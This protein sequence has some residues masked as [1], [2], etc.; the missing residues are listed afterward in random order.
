MG[1]RPH[2]V[3]GARLF[4]ARRWLLC[5][6]A[7]LQGM[8]VPPPQDPACG[9]KAAMRSNGTGHQPILEITS[10]VELPEGCAPHGD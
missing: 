9:S 1:C 8:A 3:R 6:R 5:P 4:V 10:R 7:G 2:R